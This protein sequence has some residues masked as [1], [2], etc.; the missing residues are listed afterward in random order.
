MKKFENAISQLND[1]FKYK[2]N[3]LENYVENL[4]LL[5][6]NQWQILN[7]NTGKIDSIS[8]KNEILENNINKI[9]NEY[10]NNTNIFNSNIEQL[11]ENY[12]IIKNALDNDIRQLTEE[13]N[14][15]KLLTNKSIEKLKDIQQIKVLKN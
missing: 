4:Q 15:Q 1:S 13:I 5:Y 6:S 10:R 9:K 11:K 8:K 2:I 7:E 12:K 14:T 3:L